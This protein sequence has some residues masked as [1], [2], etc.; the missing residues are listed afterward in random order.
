MASIY[1]PTNIIGTNQ[2]PERQAPQEGKRRPAHSLSEPA[3]R[4]LSVDRFVWQVMFVP[5]GIENTERT[6][7]GDTE[8]PGEVPHCVSSIIVF[9]Q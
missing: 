2:R 5:H 1:A 3:E 9:P 8:N 6:G 4:P 7:E